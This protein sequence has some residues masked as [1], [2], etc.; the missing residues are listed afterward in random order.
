[1][2]LTLDEETRLQNTE[3]TT[4][5]LKTLIDGAGSKNQLKELTMLANEQIRRLE[6]RVTTL[7]SDVTT[8]LAL[9]QSLQ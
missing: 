9:A 1:M 3:E 5:Q 2:A 6:A 4:Q 8:L 7:E